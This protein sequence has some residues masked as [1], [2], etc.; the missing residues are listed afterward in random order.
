MT[1]SQPKDRRPGPPAQDED[2]DHLVRQAMDEHSLM[3]GNRPDPYEADRLWYKQQRMKYAITAFVILLLAGGATWYLVDRNNK[4][5]E[6]EALDAEIRA[7]YEAQLSNLAERV[8]R[9]VRELIGSK[10]FKLARGTLDKARG[11]GLPPELWAGLDVELNSALSAHCGRLIEETEAELDDRDPDKAEALMVQLRLLEVP[12]DLLSRI[13]PLEGRLRDVR[14]QV[15]L[16]PAKRLVTESRRAT[17]EKD[18]DKA[19]STMQRARQLPREGPELDL[20]EN[21]LR[22]IV[23]GRVLVT[24]T[25]ASAQVEVAGHSPVKIGEQL[26]GLDMGNVDFVVSADGYLSERGKADVSFP[27]LA[28]MSVEL[29]PEAPGPVWATQVLTGRCAQRVASSFYLQGDLD[30]EW[31]KAVKSVCSASP[32]CNVEGAKNSS[33]DKDELL[34]DAVKDFER[35]RDK[36]VV[37]AL[38][39]LGEF[40]AKY[41]DS[42]KAVLARCRSDLQRMLAQIERGCG[43]CWGAG[44]KPCDEC[45]ARGKRKELRPCVACK[46]TGQKTHVPCGGTGK[47]KCKKCHGKG[48]IKKRRKEGKSW[49]T[50]SQSCGACNRGKINCLCGNGKIT[51]SKCKGNRESK[52]VGDCSG[53]AGRGTLPCNVCGGSGG[54]SSMEFDRRRELEQAIARLNGP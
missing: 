26:A 23:G 53:C 16:E 37:L 40:T 39:E 5:K 47:I 27:A 36:H 42:T 34:D 35:G 24:G 32:P 7:K 49:V 2:L 10:S 20:W 1:A 51:C 18:Y 31:A 33:K 4:R 52:Q 38:D 6:R 43:D 25:P 8:P 3:P 17:L 45:K 15:E 48:T 13:A 22:D 29:V 11:E 54:R 19:I 44:D 46:A 9:E 50:R 14:R 28:T 30:A 12:G 41:P 21:E